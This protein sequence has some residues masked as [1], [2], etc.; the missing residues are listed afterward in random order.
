[1]NLL[2]KIILVLVSAAA[3]F[4]Q[5]AYVPG[6]VSC[7]TGQMIVAA[8]VASSLT[9]FTLLHFSCVALDS[10]VKLDASA[11]PATIRSVGAATI[12]FAGNE[13]PAG[14]LDGKNAVFQLAHAPIGGTLLLFRNGL[15]QTAGQDFAI[16]GKVLTWSPYVPAAS[17]LINCSY[18]F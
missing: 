15:K 2:L 12:N 10:S 8:P 16:S 4:G 18:F 6:V 1:M 14:V 13:T 3:A 17:D 5:A 7:P 9:G 11:T